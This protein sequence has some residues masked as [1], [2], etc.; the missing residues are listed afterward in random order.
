MKFNG[1]SLLKYTLLFLIII[2]G[3]NSYTQTNSK[4]GF[5]IGGFF[6]G[7]DYSGDLANNPLDFKR[8]SI[9]GG[10]YY[11]YYL[12]SGFQIRGRFTQQKIRGD[13]ADQNSTAARNL[14][15]ESNITEFAGIL[16]WE[17]ESISLFNYR[18]RPNIYAG[19]G[20]FKFNPKAE[21][22]GRLVELQPLGTE[23][24]G[25]SGF[26]EPYE[27]T[28]FVI[29]FG[30]G[31]K[32]LAQ[33]NIMLEVD[34]SSK[35]VFTDYLDDVSGQ[36]YVAPSI[37]IQNGQDAVDLGYR[38]DEI[39]GIPFSNFE[40]PNVRAL[41]PR[42]ISRL[43]DWYYLFSV[44]ASYYFRPGAGSEIKKNRK[45]VPNKYSRY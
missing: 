31:I 38:A 6:G 33:E 30:F 4:R 37:L 35:K 27:L 8:A 16:S 29:P 22:D 17:Y 14:S 42:N 41:N 32:Y 11:G 34:L 44:G 40:D 7:S 9:G 13:D 23:G 5:Q 36:E 12:G 19:A 1:I 45:G 20:A 3:S 43:D 2:V 28:Q 25:I 15:F 24:Q 26:D 39:G 21:L 10:A 18:L